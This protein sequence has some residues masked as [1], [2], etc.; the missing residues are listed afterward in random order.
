M[1]PAA[2]AVAVGTVTDSKH[3][4]LGGSEWPLADAVPAE[5]RVL[6]LVLV[7][8]TYAGIPHS[9][10]VKDSSGDRQA[11]CMLSIQGRFLSRSRLQGSRV[12]HKGISQQ[13][14]HKCMLLCQGCPLLGRMLK[15]TR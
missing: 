12:Q 3:H 9:N 14:L 5:A 6:E 13:D 4:Q 7:R 10:V 8:C 1:R 11:A 2:S 15:H